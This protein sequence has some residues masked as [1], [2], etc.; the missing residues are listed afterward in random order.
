LFFSFNTSRQKLDDNFLNSIVSYS[1]G[2]SEFSASG[3]ISKIDENTSFLDKNIV[4]KNSLLNT[5][6]A[7]ISD[8]TSINLETT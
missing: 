7:K 3:N 4:F 5:I 8:K 6:F 2:F 1:S